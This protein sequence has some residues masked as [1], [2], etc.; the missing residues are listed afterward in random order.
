ML[1]RIPTSFFLL[2]TEI[3]KKVND[4]ENFT[5]PIDYIIGFITETKGLRLGLNYFT[6]V[7][8]LFTFRGLV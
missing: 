7:F 8:T 4:D 3:L 2:H 5:I 6:I 1:L